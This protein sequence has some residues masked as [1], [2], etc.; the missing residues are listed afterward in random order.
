MSA[1]FGTGLR[2]TFDFSTAMGFAI[3]AAGGGGE[4][5]GGVVVDPVEAGTIGA[6][7]LACEGVNTGSVRFSIVFSFGRLKLVGGAVKWGLV[8]TGLV[9]VLVLE[10]APL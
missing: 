1:D 5:G 10:L 9:S 2:A 6:G 4:K 7:E 3:C 8:R